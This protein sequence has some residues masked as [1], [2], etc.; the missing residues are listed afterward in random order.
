MRERRE[1]EK[2]EKKCFFELSCFFSSSSS[3]KKSVCVCVCCSCIRESVRTTVGREETH[4]KTEEKS[5][6][7]S[8]HS[9]P[10]SLSLFSF[11]CPPF[12]PQPSPASDTSLF[13]YPSHSYRNGLG[14]KRGRQTH[15]FFIPLSDGLRFFKSIEEEIE[16][17]REKQKES[18]SLQCDIETLSLPHWPLSRASNTQ[19]DTPTHLGP[20]ISAW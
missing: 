8:F 2:R 7:K 9:L 13:S 15:I 20:Y 6:E 11:L 1:R 5:R 14:G 3:E 18:Q 16:R 10:L 19:L 4:R 17:E 12:T